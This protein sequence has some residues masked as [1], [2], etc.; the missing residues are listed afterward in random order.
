MFFFHK[1]P[2]IQPANQPER[3]RERER[4][5]EK[6]RKREREIGDDGESSQIDGWCLKNTEGLVWGRVNCASR[7]SRGDVSRGDDPRNLRYAVGEMW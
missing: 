6:E 3:G 4:E 1:K 7:V 2:A 5:R